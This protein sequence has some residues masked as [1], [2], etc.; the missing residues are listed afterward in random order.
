MT[1][2][3]DN[4]DLKK[5]LGP[6]RYSA[7]GF[8]GTDGRRPEDIIRDDE[9]TLKKLGVEK[10]RL[11]EALRSASA[12]AEK[13]LGAPVAVSDGVT[14]ESRDWRGRTPSPF[15]SE[16]TFSKGETVF[17]DEKTGDSFFVSPLSLHL[18]D[19]HGF[20]QGKGSP[21]RVEPDI[22]A[23]MLGLIG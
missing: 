7:Q 22:A 21:Y 17:T 20:F 18:I 5:L 15:P 8:L 2:H 9:A 12:A 4:A 6:S 16:G 3:E 1:S 13:A 19:K 23:R 14:A 10:S 11:V